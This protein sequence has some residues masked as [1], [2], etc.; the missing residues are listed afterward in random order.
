VA[1]LELPLALRAGD[2]A[3]ATVAL[4]AV[5]T[6]PPDTVTLEL[7]DGTRPVARARIAV[8]SGGSFVRELRFVPAPP[9]G[10]REVRRYVVRVRG[11]AA[12]AEPRDDARS[13]VVEITREST[14]ALFS[15]SPDWDFRA[16]VTTLS[17][18]SGVPVRAF[19]HVADG[20]WREAGTLKPATQ[21]AVESAAREAALVVVH[22]TPQ[23]AAP[24][25]ALARRSVWR[26]TSA[27][28]MAG[29]GDWYVVPV[30]APSPLG[31]A[32]AGVPAESL[33]PLEAV[34]AAAGDSDGWVALAAQL[35]RR[36]R[37][38]AV[39]V[40]SEAGSRHMV[41]VRASG[42]WRWAAKGGVASEGYRALTAAITDW[43]LAEVPRPGGE[44]A[45]RRDS[46]NRGLDEV[47]PRP[48]TLKAQPGHP[49]AA[50]GEPVPLRHLPWAY[51]AALGALM[52]E[53]IARRRKG[54][55]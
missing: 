25:L 48:R 17:A 40:G 8:G 22:G 24:I 10:D 12:D 35:A 20:P 32:L 39:I 55:R 54:M 18:T 38:R 34:S 6:A 33:P 27:R 19:V 1:G 13:V 37:L 26:W 44:L 5:G 50:A 11:L 3:T 46:L 15:D 47:L 31:A 53:W 21:R 16:L 7:L 9:A 36:G 51:A 2:T 30:E 45:S 43:L 14:I 23:G 52:I 42:L 49:L 41:Q 4:V 28:G 29:T